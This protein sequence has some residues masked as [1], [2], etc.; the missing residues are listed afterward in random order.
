MKEPTF[1]TPRT[2]KN[3]LCRRETDSLIRR[4]DP[5]WSI[6]QFRQMGILAIDHLFGLLGQLW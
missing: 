1:F 2:K 4:D 5:H 6:I 3:I